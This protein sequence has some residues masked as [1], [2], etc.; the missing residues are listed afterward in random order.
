MKFHGY[1]ET[2]VFGIYI[3]FTYDKQLFAGAFQNKCS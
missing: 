2:I 3:N 1:S